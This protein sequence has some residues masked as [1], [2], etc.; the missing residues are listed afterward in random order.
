ME[1]SQIPRNCLECSNR[2]SCFRSW[3]GNG[4]CKYRKEI[5]QAVTREILSTEGGNEN[6]RNDTQTEAGHPCHLPGP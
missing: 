6:G 2:Y 1:E 4:Q 5:H 3:Y